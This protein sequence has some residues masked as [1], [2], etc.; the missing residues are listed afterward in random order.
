M[1]Q[2]DSRLPEFLESAGVAVRLLT[3]VERQDAEQQWRAIYG[4]AF[5]D[6]R[7]RQG[8]KADFEYAQQPACRWFAVPLSSGVEG[9]LASPIARTVVGC[10]CYGPVVPMGDICDVEFVVSPTDLSWTMLYTH[11]DHDLGGP[12]F[13]RREWLPNGLL[14]SK[15]MANK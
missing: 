2:R 13:I 4:K 10:E 14:D 7:L 9:T 8:S 3:E 6:G 5:R 11:E 12:F 1:V 15:S